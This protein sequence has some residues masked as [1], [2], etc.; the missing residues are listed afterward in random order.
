MTLTDLLIC[1]SVY[2]NDPDSKR[3][4]RYLREVCKI[5]R[6]CTKCQSS[7]LVC[8]RTIKLVS[9]GQYEDAIHCLHV[10]YEEFYIREGS[11]L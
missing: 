3:L 11:N 10:G 6:D 2:R 4:A 8:R 5:I 1:Y 7:K 9:L